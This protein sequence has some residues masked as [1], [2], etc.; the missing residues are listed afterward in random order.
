VLVTR[1]LGSDIYGYSLSTQ[2]GENL[3]TNPTPGTIS[4]YTI[5]AFSDPGRPSRFTTTRYAKPTV[6]DPV[7]TTTVLT[8]TQM[9]EI[10]EIAKKIEMAYCKA[11]P[12]YYPNRNCN[13]V[14]QDKTKPLSLDMEIKVLPD[15]HY[16][17]K[18]VREF[19]GK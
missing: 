16:L 4:E 6:T 10:V 3:V 1:V 12:S 11:K 15:G 13:T 5:A 19:H 9:S 14:W 18:Q 7:R 2:V 8:Q 17:F